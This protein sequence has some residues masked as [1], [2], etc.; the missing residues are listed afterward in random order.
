MSAPAAGKVAGGGTTATIVEFCGLPGAGKSYI[1]GHVLNTLSDHGVVA[2]LRDDGIGPDVAGHRRI[3]RK[4][5]WALEQ[6]VTRPIASM[7]VLGCIGAGQ[8]D[9]SSVISRSVQWFV[10]QGLLDAARHTAGVHLFQEGVLQVLWSIGLRGEVR[11]LLRLL[12]EG[13]VPWSR[14]DLVVVVDASSEAIRR[15]LQARHSRHSRTQELQGAELDVELR[16]GADLLA[17]LVGWWEQ[18]GGRDRLLW[19][20]NDSDDRP[21]VGEVVGFIQARRSA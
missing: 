16:R 2:R 17:Q 9:W 5:R 21:V 19:V 8:R 6:E 11:K 15:R 1:A 12:D 4:L 20:S 18:R 13:A 7:R 10:T 3:S 14:P